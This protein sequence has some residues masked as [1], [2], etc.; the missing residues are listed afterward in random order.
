MTDHKEK[1]IVY[2]LVMAGLILLLALGVALLIVGIQNGSVS[3]IP[4][5][6]QKIA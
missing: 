3:P 4:L 2:R 5:W 6:D 1:H